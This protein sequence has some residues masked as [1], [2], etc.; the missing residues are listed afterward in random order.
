MSEEFSVEKLVEALSAESGGLSRH[1][2]EENI[3]KGVELKTLMRD[4]QESDAF[5]TF[6]ALLKQQCDF[7]IDE[8]CKTRPGLDG[9]VENTHTIGEIAGLRIALNFAEALIEQASDSIKMNQHMMDLAIEE[10]EQDNG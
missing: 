4:L 5:K 3:R 7:R 1:S 8:L 9:A 6:C 2:L 10:E